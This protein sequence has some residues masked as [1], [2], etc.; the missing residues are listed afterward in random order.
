MFLLGDPTDP[1]AV[2]VKATLNGGMYENAWIQQGEVLRYF[3]KSRG[4]IFGLHFQENAAIIRRPSIPVLCFVRKSADERFRYEGIFGSH[5][6]NEE[7]GG[8][9]WFRLIRVASPKQIVAATDIGFDQQ[10]LAEEVRLA[11]QLGANEL[12]KK[13]LE[14]PAIPARQVLTTIGFKRSPYVI[15][16]VLRRAQGQCELCARPAPFARRDGSPYLEVHHRI[17][18]ADGGHDTVDN[19]IAACPNCHRQ[20]HFGAD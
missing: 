12:A 6:V 15:S 20:A 18:L 9:R 13:L 2:V 10:K 4:G 7:P 1:E 3:L 11:N 19:A 17:R 16:A 8:A 14:S 5:G